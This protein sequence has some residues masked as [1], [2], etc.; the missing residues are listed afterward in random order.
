ML[1]LTAARIS[2]ESEKDSFISHLELRAEI[3][4]HAGGVEKRIF[5]SRILALGS[6]LVGELENVLYRISDGSRSF[7]HRLLVGR[8]RKL[9]QQSR[10]LKE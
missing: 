9:L 4:R 5:E 6:D 1:A 7:D 2:I 3:L 8:D 10:N